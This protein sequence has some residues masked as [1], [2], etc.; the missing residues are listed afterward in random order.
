MSLGVGSRK[1]KTPMV[2]ETVFLSR[3][4]EKRP[5]NG[6]VVKAQNIFLTQHFGNHAGLSAHVVSTAV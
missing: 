4:R 5:K 3:L 2:A 6:V 1:K